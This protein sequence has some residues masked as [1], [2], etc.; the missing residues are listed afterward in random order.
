MNYQTF[1]LPRLS[2][3]L[4]TIE[5]S[6]SPGPNF[7]SNAKQTICA[8]NPTIRFESKYTPC[9]QTIFLIDI[10]FKFGKTNPISVFIEILQFYKHRT[11]SITSPQSVHPN[12][13]LWSATFRNHNR[14]ESFDHKFLRPPFRDKEREMF[15]EQIEFETELERERL[16]L[17]LKFSM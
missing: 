1:S 3:K 4:S 2:P 16:V 6:A 7:A 13:H 5:R 11:E 10:L 8:T 12:P 17:I 14:R 9:K 15:E